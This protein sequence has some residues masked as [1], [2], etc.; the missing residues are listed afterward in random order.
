MLSK[1]QNSPKQGQKLN[2][3]ILDCPDA[4]VQNRAAAA[5]RRSSSAADGGPARGAGGGLEPRA[6][7]AC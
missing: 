2:Q 1:I 4:A 7:T 3:S 6:A 5:S